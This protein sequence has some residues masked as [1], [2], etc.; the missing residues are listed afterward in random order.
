MSPTRRVAAVE[1]TVEG[2]A[3]AAAAVAAVVTTGAAGVTV[4][5]TGVAGPIADMR[6][7]GRAMAVEAMGMGPWAP[8]WAATASGVSIADLTIA[9]ATRIAAGIAIVGWR[10][11]M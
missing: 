3:V 4:G 5:A 9:G 6:A 10:L 1:G 7:A 2:A 11:A 8:P